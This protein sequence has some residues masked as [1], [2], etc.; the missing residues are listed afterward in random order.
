MRDVSR[1]KPQGR[2]GT[3]RVR[4]PG[5]VATTEAP[6]RHA[7][8]CTMQSAPELAKLLG[9]E[10]EDPEKDFN[11]NRL[12]SPRGHEEQVSEAE[13]LQHELAAVKK[14]RSE[15]IHSLAHIKT[16]L[17]GSGG[18]EAQTMQLLQLEKELELKKLTL[19]ELRTEGKKLT[20][21]IADTE[22]QI[23][24][25][26][27]LTPG[28]YEGEISQIKQ[29]MSDMA[30]LEED[31][32]EAEAKN[33]CAHGSA[34]SDR[35]EAIPP[36]QSIGMCCKCTRSL[37]ARMLQF[38]SPSPPHPQ[39]AHNRLMM[40]RAR[41]LYYLLGERTRADHLEMDRKVRVAREHKDAGLEDQAALAQ[42]L[43]DVRAGKEDAERQLSHLRRMLD[44]AKKDWLKK[45]KD[46]KKEVAELKR[47]QEREELR[48]LKRRDLP[49]HVAVFASAWLLWC[50]VAAVHGCCVCVCMVAPGFAALW[51]L[52]TLGRMQHK[53]VCWAQQAGSCAVALPVRYGHMGGRWCHGTSRRVQEGAAGGGRPQ[54]AG[55]A[56]QGRARA[57]GARRAGRGARAEDRGDGG[58][59]ESAA[60]D[61]GRGRAGGGDR[62]LGGAQE[63]G[64]EHAAAR[65]GVGGD[66]GGGQGARRLPRTCL[67]GTWLSELAR[68]SL[69][70]V[71][72]RAAGVA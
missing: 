50:M 37:I 67:P 5:Q 39:P 32:I 48:E 2:A 46:R 1:P 68:V 27:L 45:M 15:I 54:G 12:D 34:Y 57:G 3:P 62:V 21:R 38:W 60:H 40:L 4:T 28:G 66:R 65:R 19:N 42:H 44:G 25:A 14:D 6:A 22:T 10:V 59:L 29:L 63:Q 20:K 17:V 23:H 26:V 30:R 16:N 56:A 41:R 64:G 52:T 18:G 8:A 70:V 11:T 47:R 49:P 55:A 9:E 13:Q 35:H 72:N 58:E 43:H 71:P 53:C 69:R 51:I 61:H 36:F 31:L 24:D 33:R 7:T